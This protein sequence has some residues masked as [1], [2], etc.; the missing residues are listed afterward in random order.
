METPADL[1]TLDVLRCDPNADKDIPPQLCW[2][3]GVYTHQLLA[4]RPSCLC[5]RGTSSKVPHHKLGQ[6]HTPAARLLNTAR[7]V[8]SDAQTSDTAFPRAAGSEAGMPAMDS[9]SPAPDMPARSSTLAD[10][11]AMSVAS[12]GKLLPAQ[13]ATPYSDPIP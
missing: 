7:L 12:A 11:L 5:C 1:V 6:R 10:D 9:Y 13:H 2:N 8:Y 3:T 4:P